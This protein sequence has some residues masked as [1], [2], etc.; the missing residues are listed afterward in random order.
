MVTAYS[1]AQVLPA[2]PS[3]Q[4]SPSLNCIYQSTKW[5]AC[6]RTCGQGISTR[7]SNRN[8]ACR[9]EKQ[10]RLCKIRP[11]LALPYQ[12][13]VVSHDLFNI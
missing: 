6:S 1:E 10:I 7:V 13:P 5:S 11:C 12:S 9:L 4:T 3:H 2:L 8:A